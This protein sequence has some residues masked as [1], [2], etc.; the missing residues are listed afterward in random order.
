[1]PEFKGASYL[2]RY[3]L[4]C[5]R[6]VQEQLYTAATLIAA[7][8]DA[9]DSGDFAQLSPVTGLKAFVTA[10]AGHVAASAARLGE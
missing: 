7:E 2:Q 8:R 6:L 3:D 1:M 9:V 10:L 5:Q 4:L